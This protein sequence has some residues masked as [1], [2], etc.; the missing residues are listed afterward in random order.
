MRSH[1]RTGR[2]G[3][4]NPFAG[5]VAGP[6]FS[7]IGVVMAFFGWRDYAATRTF[8]AGAE[9]ANG[10]V[11]E[12]VQRTSTD[13]DGNTN[14]YYYPVVEFTTAGGQAVRY[15]SST[16]SSRTSQQVGDVVDM[17]YA[18]EN[19]QNARINTFM[20]IWFL[21]AMLLGMGV[22]FALAGVAAFFNSIALIAGLGGLLALL[23]FWRKKSK[24]DQNPPANVP[25]S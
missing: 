12:L 14:T 17:V 13:S 19:P 3:F 16:G 11:V 8:L 23:F 18:P 10:S 2:G 4:R 21:P 6:I 25:G 24:Q 1:I 15:Q 20:D 9:H 22:I 5:I 7:I